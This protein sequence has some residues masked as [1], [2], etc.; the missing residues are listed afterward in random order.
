MDAETRTRIFEPFFTTKGPGKGTG[1]GLATVYGIVQQSGGGISVE[2][3]P[4][5]ATKFTRLPAARQ[6]ADRARGRAVPTA[7]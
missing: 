4:G 6:R 2:S 7:R 3:R 1:L 5:R